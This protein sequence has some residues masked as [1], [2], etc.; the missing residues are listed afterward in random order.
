MRVLLI[1]LFFVSLQQDYKSIKNI[2]VKADKF[3]TD[4]MGNCYLVDRQ[5]I[6]KYDNFGRKLSSYSNGALGNITYVDASNPLRILLLY[7]NFNQIVLLDNSFAEI[8]EPFYLDNAGID[9][10][11]VACISN[12]GGIW[13]YNSTDM[14]LQRYNTGMNL[15]QTG[16]NLSDLIDGNQTP[17]FLVEKNDNI[18]LNFPK[19]GIFVFDNLGVYYKTIPIKGLK[20]F[21]INGSFIRYFKDNKIHNYN[22]I[23]LRETEINLPDTTDVIDASLVNKYLFIFK[24]DWLSI[25]RKKK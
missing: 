22:H 12:F 21:D 11:D 3:L 6:T 8:T 15:E 2:P 19:T 10:I 18:Y 9:M 13:V 24:H 5:E 20:R 23:L 16:T 14:E 17:N 7:K 4:I 25:Y 1:F